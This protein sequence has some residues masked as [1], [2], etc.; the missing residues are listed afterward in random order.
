MI[1]FFLLIATL[2]SILLQYFICIESLLRY[3]VECAEMLLLT[4]LK[5][6]YLGTL[7]K[8]LKLVSH[9]YHAF[10]FEGT[11]NSFF[12]YSI[13][14]GRV[15]SRERIIKQVDVCILIDGPG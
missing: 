8:E 11:Q 12:K 2:V 1:Y 9:Q 4:I 5:D 3:L 13:C 6:K 7:P 15:H 14:H 10:I